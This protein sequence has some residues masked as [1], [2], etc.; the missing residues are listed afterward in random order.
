MPRRALGGLQA[1]VR[2]GTAQCGVPTSWARRGVRVLI[3]LNNFSGSPH[4][5]TSKGDGPA[6]VTPVMTLAAQGGG[7]LLGPPF[8]VLLQLR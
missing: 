3:A 6:W 4:T 7:C 1:E 8:S 5:A 2:A